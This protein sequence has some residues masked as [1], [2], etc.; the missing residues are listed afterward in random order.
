MIKKRKDNVYMKFKINLNRKTIIKYCATYATNLDI[1]QLNAEINL[2]SL[3]PLQ[4]WI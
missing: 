2:I 3:Y 1:I 4:G